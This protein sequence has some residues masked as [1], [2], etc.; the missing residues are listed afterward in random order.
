VLLISVLYNLTSG[1]QV[2]ASGP[3]D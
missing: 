3:V 2:I 1:Y